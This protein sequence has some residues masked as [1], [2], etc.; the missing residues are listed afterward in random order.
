MIETSVI[1]Y[2]RYFHVLQAE[3]TAAKDEL[4]G[5]PCTWQSF[6]SSNLRYAVTDAKLGLYV[7]TSL[8]ARCVR[9]LI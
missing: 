4:I 9:Q 1:E 5:D 2:S 6:G 8:D 7:Y 3:I